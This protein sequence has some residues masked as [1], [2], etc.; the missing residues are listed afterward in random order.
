MCQTEEWAVQLYEDKSSVPHDSLG[1]ERF[2]DVGDKILAP[3]PPHF[4]S[5]FREIS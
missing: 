3:I 2:P 5:A 4:V 1:E